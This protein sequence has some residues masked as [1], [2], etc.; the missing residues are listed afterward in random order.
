MPNLRVTCTAYRFGETWVLQDERVLGDC[1]VNDSR[2]GEVPPWRLNFCTGTQLIRAAL[3][4]VKIPLNAC[5]ETSLC[6]AL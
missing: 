3:N 6:L 2:G 1:V 4:R 5:S